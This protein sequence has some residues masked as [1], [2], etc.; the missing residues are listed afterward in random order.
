MLGTA[1]D[2]IM[3]IPDEGQGFQ[4]S[5]H[6]AGLNVQEQGYHHYVNQWMGRGGAM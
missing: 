5:S 4:H 3:R 2:E 1:Y 6:R